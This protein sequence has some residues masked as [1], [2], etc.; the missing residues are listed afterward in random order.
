MELPYMFVIIY[1]CV[2]S[3]EHIDSV[4]LKREDAEKRLQECKHLHDETFLVK[5]DGTKGEKVAI[6]DKVFYESQYPVK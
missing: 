2:E 6:L 4:W 1:D 3:T 5:Y